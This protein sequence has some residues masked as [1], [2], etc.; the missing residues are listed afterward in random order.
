M[1]NFHLTYYFHIIRNYKIIALYIYDNTPR[2]T[3]FF[4][5]NSDTYKLYV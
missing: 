4:S 2:S 3:L 5:I 1:I